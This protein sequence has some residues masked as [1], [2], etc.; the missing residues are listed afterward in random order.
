MGVD[1]YQY[2]IVHTKKDRRNRKDHPRK[3][4]KIF[5]RII[6]LKVTSLLLDVMRVM[7]KATLL[8]IVLETSDPQEQKR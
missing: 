5:Q 6:D 8:E 3:R 2:L 7:R 4:P 1:D